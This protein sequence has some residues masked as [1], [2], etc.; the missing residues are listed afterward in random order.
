MGIVMAPLLGA[1]G[2]YTQQT[3]W[4]YKEE[5]APEREPRA[6]SLS[7]LWHPVQNPESQ[8]SAPAH[9]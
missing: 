4:V 7:A 8:V 2:L 3:F 9:V 5:W 1:K 6:A